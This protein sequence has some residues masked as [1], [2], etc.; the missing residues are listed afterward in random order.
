MKKM[1]DIFMLFKNIVFP[2]RCIFC[3]KTLEP[4]VKRHICGVCGKNIEFCADSICCEKCGK[5]ILGFGERPL[6][7]FCV[8][9][10]SKYFNRI[11]SSFCYEGMVRDAIVRFKKKGI[12]AYL[13]V[14]ADSIVARIFEEYCGIEF[15]FVCSAPPHNKKKNGFDQ[16]EMLAKRVS[17]KLGLPFKCGLFKLTRKTSKQSELKFR[18]RLENM[19]DSLMVKERALISGKVVL[20]I[21]DVCTTRATISECSRA[22]KKAGAKAVYAVTVATVKNKEG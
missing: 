8:N 12:R 21:D 9:G 22:L 4:N 7:Y 13:D 20:L 6:C 5:P 16:A 15:D 11:I 10:K 1:T 2:P 17:A 14:F 3:G 18:E 19:K